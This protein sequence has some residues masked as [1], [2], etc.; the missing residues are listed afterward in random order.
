MFME[1]GKYMCYH[2]KNDLWIYKVNGR[3][4]GYELCGQEGN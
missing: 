4:I 1:K 3:I 2:E